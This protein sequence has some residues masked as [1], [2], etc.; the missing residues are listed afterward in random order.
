MKRDTVGNDDQYKVEMLELP[1]MHFT[2]RHHGLRQRD[3]VDSPTM[4]KGTRWDEKAVALDK[5]RPLTISLSF[6]DL[7]NSLTY[8]TRPRPSL[9]IMGQKWV[10][11]SSSDLGFTAPSPNSTQYSVLKLRPTH[12]VATSV[13]T[14]L[15]HKYL[16]LYIFTCTV[17]TTPPSIA[18]LLLFSINISPWTSPHQ[19]DVSVI[20]LVN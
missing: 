9:W 20:L 5:Y 7:R 18:I 11:P 10:R 4:P 8:L 14:Y 2:N 3:T 12:G 13:V 19:Q 17:L 15:V 1:I 16:Y 6:S